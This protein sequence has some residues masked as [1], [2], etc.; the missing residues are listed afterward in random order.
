MGEFQKSINRLKIIKTLLFQLI[1]T[2]FQKSIQ[3]F[4]NTIKTHIKNYGKND[5]TEIAL[6]KTLLKKDFI[7][8]IYKKLNGQK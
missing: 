8:I 3:F 5:W 1:F 6:Q 7:L 4:F 2:S